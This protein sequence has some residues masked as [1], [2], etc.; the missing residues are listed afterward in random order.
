MGLYADRAL[1]WLMDRVMGLRVMR[2]Q[3]GP[4]LALARGRVLEIGFGCGSSLD[5]YPRN[6][7]RVS[8]LVGLDPSPGM[9]VRAEGR[10]AKAP[11]PVELIRAGAES[12]PMPEAEFDTVISHWTLCSVRDL[13]VALGEVRRVLRLDGLFLFLEHGRAQDE[14]VARRQE[15]WSPVQR[16]IAGGCR[17]D[18]PVDRRIREAG[19]EIESLERYEARPAPRVLAQMYRGVARHARERTERP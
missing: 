8:S 12:I 17:L 3:R 19:L 11:F 2:D 7:S 13:R 14:G 4:S 18:V 6:G 15:R 16:R 5:G 9:L 10:A 1:P